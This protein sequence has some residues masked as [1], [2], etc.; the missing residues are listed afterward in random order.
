MDG[1][2]PPQIV[3]KIHVTIFG[4]SRTA[5][6]SSTERGASNHYNYPRLSRTRMSNLYPLPYLPQVSVKQGLL[7][8]SGK[9]FN[10]GIPFGNVSDDREGDST[11]YALVSQGAVVPSMDMIP[12]LLP[13]RL[14]NLVS[15][16]NSNQMPPSLGASRRFVANPVPLH[17][18]TLAV[19]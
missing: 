17:L 6:F 16:L 2:I 1:P 11:G 5:M 19:S 7:H 8:K 9:I 4:S 12:L 3:R 18:P 13:R 10:Y 15:W 14:L